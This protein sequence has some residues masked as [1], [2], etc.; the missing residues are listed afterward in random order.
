VEYVRAIEQ[1]VIDTLADFHIDGSRVAGASGVWVR[2]SKVAAI[3]IHISRWVTSHG[4]ALN[5]D[6][7][8]DYFR[9]I[10]PCGLTKPVTSMRAL[11]CNAT[12]AEVTG[13]LS[14]NFGKIFGRSL[15]LL[16][17]S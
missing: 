13:A 11:G 10:V 1:V 2:E 15:R 5:L 12:R 17:R 3:G 4:F 8:L 6:T 16:E 7:D 9:Y 14:R